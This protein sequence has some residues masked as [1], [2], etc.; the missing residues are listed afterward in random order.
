[1][2][3]VPIA[4]VATLVT[5]ADGQQIIIIINEALWFG[6]TMRHTLVSTNQVRSYGVQL[7]DNPCNPH[8]PLAILNTT[9]SHLVPLEMD[10]IVA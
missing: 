5:D 9:T 1:M 7:W 3:S 4:A 2:A 6:P 8:H 10:G